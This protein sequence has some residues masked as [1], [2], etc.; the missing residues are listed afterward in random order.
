[1][2]IFLKRLILEGIIF[3]RGEN[4]SG[5]RI[6]NDPL[7]HA[8]NVG[9]IFVSTSL[10]HAQNYGDQI[11]KFIPTSDAKILSFESSDFWK[12]IGKKMPPNKWLGS[13]STPKENLFILFN[14]IIDIAK[15]N[16]Y[17]AVIFSNT[18]DIGSVILNPEKFKKEVIW[19]RR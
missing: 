1:M 3:Y 19:H 6:Q 15:L 10:R 17:D 12:L 9:G 11:T 14:R 13:V 18:D 8:K 4:N 16:D 5:K 2:A 7:Q